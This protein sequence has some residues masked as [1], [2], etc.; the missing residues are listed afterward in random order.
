MIE[1]PQGID[2]KLVGGQFTIQ[3][4][5]GSKSGKTMN[6]SGC[7]YDGETVEEMNSRIDLLH[8][9]L[10]R[11]VVRG[12]IPGLEAEVDM[13]FKALRDHKVHLEGLQKR[14]AE[15]GTSKASMA[16]KEC[17]TMQLQI[18][19]LIKSITQIQIDVDKG[20][21]AVQ[22]AKDKLKG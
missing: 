14:R 8:D 7:V 12:E 15:L 22:Q 18:D 3:A 20:M 2:H 10:D 1:S 9:L 4:Q 13:R 5:L 21:L 11:Q 6:I 16:K 19:N 17:E